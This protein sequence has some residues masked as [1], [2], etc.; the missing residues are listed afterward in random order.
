VERHSCVESK[1]GIGWVHESLLLVGLKAEYNKPEIE[2]RHEDDAAESRDSS[3]GLGSSRE[4]LLQSKE[5]QSCHS[6]YEPNVEVQ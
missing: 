5:W 1:C 2:W 6:K 3:T 4:Y